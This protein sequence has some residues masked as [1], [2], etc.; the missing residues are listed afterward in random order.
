MVIFC[1]SGFD[2]YFWLHQIFRPFSTRV[3]VLLLQQMAAQHAH[4][5]VNILPE[6]PGILKGFFSSELLRYYEVMENGCCRL[7]HILYKSDG[8]KNIY[9][10]NS[11]KW[12]RGAA[13]QERW[14]GSEC[15]LSVHFWTDAH[16][17]MADMVT[18][19]GN[20]PVNHGAD[21]RLPSEEAVSYRGGGWWWSTTALPPE[22]K[23]CFYRLYIRIIKWNDLTCRLPSN[24]FI[25]RDFFS[26]RLLS[27]YLLH[28]S[29]LGHK[30]YVWGLSVQLWYLRNAWRTLFFFHYIQIEQV[31]TVQSD[32]CVWLA[33]SN[34]LRLLLPLCVNTSSVAFT[35]A[36]WSRR[37]AAITFAFFV[38]VMWR[39]SHES[40]KH[41]ISCVSCGKEHLQPFRTQSVPYFITSVQSFYQTDRRARRKR[42]LIIRR[43]IYRPCFGKNH[44]EKFERQQ[45]EPQSSV[46]R[47]GA[48]PTGV[49]GLSSVY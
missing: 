19:V 27:F 37:P 23:V 15:V 41:Y 34:N 43:H 26:F 33:R 28:G 36:K 21:D 14:S 13:R 46:R 40:M 7:E 3:S 39:I 32:A 30:D 6:W 35:A 42:R 29:S 38:L 18:E 45:E 24:T 1:F 16:H 22:Y 31:G 5:R 25:K 9:I 4:T 20:K 11:I 48:T 17:T 47:S 2:H 8:G 49:G 10:F 12:R 44:S